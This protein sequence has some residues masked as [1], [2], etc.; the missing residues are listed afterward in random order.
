MPSVFDL[1]REPVIA[2]NLAKG[3]ACV[4]TFAWLVLR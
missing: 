3:A 1:L 4:A 2:V